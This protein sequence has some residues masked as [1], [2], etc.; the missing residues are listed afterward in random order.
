MNI[1]IKILNINNITKNDI[2]IVKKKMPI[3]YA[4]IS[5]IKNEKVKKTKLASLMHIIKNLNCNEEDIIYNEYN[6][7][8]LKNNNKYFNI[9]NAEDISIYVEDDAPIGIDIE[10]IDNKN[11]D[12]KNYAFNE[13]E[14]IYIN[15]NEIDNMHLLWTRKEAFVKMLGTGFVGKPSE[16]R[17]DFCINGKLNDVIKY[18]ESICY[19][20]TK[21]YKN[22]YI[23]ICSMKQ[24][25][26]ID[27]IN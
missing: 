20:I 17:I 8:M 1:I 16:L 19:F 9:S 4:E 27:M 5:N 15:N 11:I 26:D 22:S 6:K 2:E 21:K 7:P 12:I 14:L 25:D 3:K 18:N 10:E 13:E 24:Y 23:S